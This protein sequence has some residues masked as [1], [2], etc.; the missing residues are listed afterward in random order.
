VS[1]DA[2][3]G[4]VVAIFF[5][6][7]HCP[8]VCPLGLAHLSRTL[9]R[10]DPAGD[11]LQVLFVTVDPERDTADRLAQYLSSFHP[12]IVGLTGKRAEIESQARAFG[13]G[14]LVP[15]H[16]PGEPYLVDHTARIFLIDRNGHIVARVPATAG[17]DELVR[18]ITP[19]LE[20]GGGRGG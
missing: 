1:L 10:I 12:S 16:E 13:V 15:E 7:T 2:F 9:E 17:A 5:G 4:R 20:A 8:D 19:L 18:E 6:Y 11:D 14:I 3:S